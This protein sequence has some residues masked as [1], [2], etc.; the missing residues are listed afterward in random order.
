MSQREAT[1]VVDDLL[2]RLP[3]AITAAADQTPGVPD[4]LVDYTNQRAAE[5]RGG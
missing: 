3:E 1:E 4:R 5:L 2:D